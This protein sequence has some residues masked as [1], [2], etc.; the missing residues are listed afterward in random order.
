MD[1]VTTH[2][3][4]GSNIFDV[5]KKYK[6]P[7]III[8][9]MS[10]SN[11]LMTYD[12]MEESLVFANDNK[13]IILGVVGQQKFK[14]D[15]LLFTPGINMKENGDTLG[16][17]YKNPRDAKNK[18]TDIFIIGRGICKAENPLKELLKYK[19]ACWITK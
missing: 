17:N 14:R 5:F 6:M 9:D 4:S 19:T 8:Q 15:F 18:G 13:E 12:Y 3:V 10:S 11:N 16:Q 2:T 1:A 7:V